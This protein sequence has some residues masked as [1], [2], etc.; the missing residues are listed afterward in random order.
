MNASSLLTRLAL[1]APLALLPA[2]VIV[3]DADGNYH[4]SNTIRGSGVRVTEQR[5]VS[6]F[7]RVQISGSGEV[8]VEVG[9]QTRV[10]VSCD[11]NLIQHLTARVEDASRCRSWSR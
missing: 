6:D 1:S 5:D 3:V 9:G 8:T 2:C 7:S 10:T 11:D 4:D